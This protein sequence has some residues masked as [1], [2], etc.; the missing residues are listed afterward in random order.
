MS[1]NFE[2]LLQIEK[3][4][5]SAVTDQKP[6]AVRSSTPELPSVALSAPGVEPE[7]NRIVQR[8]FF[9]GS[10]VNCHHVV[11]C[12]IEAIN[13]SSSIGAR[14][15]RALAAKSRERVCLIDANP[16]NGGVSGVFGIPP[17]P[18]D[19]Q[20]CSISESC[21][22]VAPGLWLVR[23]P[24]TSAGGELPSTVELR[25]LFA[26]LQQD[27]SYVLIDAPGLLLNEDATIWGQI[28]D[29]AVLIVE[30]DRSHRV[31]ARS[32]KQKLETAGARF[33]GT[34]LHNRSFPV[35]K[36]LYDRL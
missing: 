24:G 8:V 16:S 32:A 9:S 36:A 22:P 11:F 25:S 10:G 13:A 14:V 28:A 6:N 7:M 18:E 30:A 4:F 29:A 17:E 35:P 23:W 12:G 3:E 34:V 20:K 2:L 5:G 19:G 27:F 31:A 1:K 26:E 21:V 15:A 33:A